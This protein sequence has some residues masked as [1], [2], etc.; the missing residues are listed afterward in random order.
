M[1]QLFKGSSIA[2]DKCPVIHLIF[3]RKKLLLAIFKCL[4]WARMQTIMICRLNFGTK[5]KVI[6]AIINL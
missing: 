2:K 4:N 3:Y 6:L 1:A 5:V